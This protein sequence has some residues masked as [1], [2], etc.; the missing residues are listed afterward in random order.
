MKR[1]ILTS[2]LVLAFALSF[3][4]PALADDSVD[5]EQV[6]DVRFSWLGPSRAISLSSSASRDTAALGLVPLPRVILSGGG[7][8]SLLAVESHTSSWR[9]GFH[10]MLE[11]ESKGEAEAG[12]LP[13]PTGDIHF[14]RGI[15]G[16]S[17]AVASDALAEEICSG[18]ALEATLSFL[19][20]GLPI[21]EPSLGLLIANGFE[22]ILGGKYWIS[23]FPGVALMITI[24]SINL[25]GD[26]LRDVLN[27]RLQ[28]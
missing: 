22:Y 27:P 6:N 14:W 15:Y 21:T 28:R 18:C 11:L 16:Y 5:A 4:A 2:V 17:L 1:S 19:G 23:F 24:F 25:V 3:A 9:L 12:F 26:H 8:F 10:G 7:D 13:F 20:I